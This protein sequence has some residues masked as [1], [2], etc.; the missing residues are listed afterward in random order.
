MTENDKIN[1]ESLQAQLSEALS[2]CYALDL[3][4]AEV[5][6]QKII[7]EY[8]AALDAYSA[9]ALIRLMQGRPNDQIQLL[10]RAL[11]RN[12][13][14]Y[15]ALHQLSVAYFRAGDFQ[16]SHDYIIRA[17]AQNPSN[18]SSLLLASRLCLQLGRWSEAYR[19]ADKVAE[20]TPRYPPQ[21]VS[22]LMADAL[23][24]SHNPLELC[25]QLL[26]AIERGAGDAVKLTAAS[27]LI[28]DLH[29][30]ERHL[31]RLQ[32]AINTSPDNKFL[33]LLRVKIL[34]Q[35]GRHDDC[36]PDLYYLLSLD[37]RDPLVFH[38]LA[39]SLLNLKRYRESLQV[40]LKIARI[41][42]TDSQLLNQ[43]GVCYRCMSNFHSASKA[44][45]RSIRL[46][47]LDA[48]IISNLGEISFRFGEHEKAMSLYSIALNINPVYKEVFYNKMLSYSVGS[49]INMQAMRTE[50]ERF[51]YIYKKT[52]IGSQNSTQAS[53]DDSEI[54]KLSYPIAKARIG[55]LSADIGN[56]C[57]SFFLASFLKYYDREKFHVELILCDR[58]YEDRESRICSYAD[59]AFSLE[60]LS[61]IKAR[62]IIRGRQY[63]VLIECNG[64][65]GGSGI[66]L[67]AERC[68]PIQC[69]YIG[70]HGSTGLD[71]IDYFISD[72][73]ILTPLVSEQLSEKPLK[74]ER[75]WLAF[76]PFEEFPK[77]ISMATINKPVL[78]FFGN[79]TKITD[80][81][82]EYWSALFQQCSEAVLV[83]KCLSFQDPYV[84]KLVL[85]KIESAGIARSRIALIEPTASWQDHLLCY[86]LIDFALDS[87][88]WSSATTG[89]DALGMG[90]PL[91]AI[92]GDTISSR[93]SS[94]LVSHLGRAEWLSTKPSDYAKLG[95]TI[96]SSY[97]QVRQQKLHLQ[98][99]VLSSSLFD[100][101][102]LAKSL[103]NAVRQVLNLDTP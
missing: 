22:S 63:N 18:E 27:W 39:E 33:R 84:A 32:Q 4:S 95:Q 46:N 94:S 78:G 62:E 97:M 36:F 10:N 13:N 53:G 93:M 49:A 56:H 23:V 75:A 43:I 24:A 85:D 7:Q 11:A 48:T 37:Q 3:D 77:A 103:E 44:F 65:T 47:P 51:W 99:E 15:A 38:S 57:V 55:I 50:A 64:Y 2:L 20:K 34:A 52:Y 89:F 25:E 26:K 41:T 45:W 67:L 71:T 74:L 12:P 21:K 68:A 92:E 79:S 31:N 40:Y 96:L 58:R 28:A 30:E 81:T 5:I 86:N 42:G 72:A 61:E 90:V 88:Q 73:H 66:S 29:H 83:L 80:I 9:L 16:L 87:T 1:A 6:L 17:L 101:L 69:H 8:P 14:H 19:L 102:D 54:A 82:L 70:Y 98:A 76:S 35:L 60:G 100:G 91:L 59:H